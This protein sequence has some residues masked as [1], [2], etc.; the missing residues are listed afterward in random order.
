MKRKG[1]CVEI[2]STENDM[3]FH[4]D[5]VAVKEKEEESPVRIIGG[6]SWLSGG[7]LCSTAVNPANWSLSVMSC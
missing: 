4:F 5:S 1:A 7:R 2:W 3:P 6:I